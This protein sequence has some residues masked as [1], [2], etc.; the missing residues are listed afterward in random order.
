MNKTFTVLISFFGLISTALA[1]GTPR[2]APPVVYAAPVC[3]G[4]AQAGSGRCNAWVV[5]N[6]KGVPIATGLQAKSNKG[7]NHG[8]KGGGGGGGGGSS[9]PPPPPPGAYGPL[10]FQTAYGLIGASSGD[11]VAIVDAYNDPTAAQDLASYSS[12][13][14]LPSCTSMNGCFKVVNQTGGTS[15]PRNNSGWALE[16]SLDVQTVH[17]VCPSCSILL[18]EAQSSS[19]SNLLAAETYAEGHSDIVSNSWGGGEFSSETSY[20]KRLGKVPTTFSAGDS[21]YGVQWP[22]ASVNVTA[23]GGTTLLLNGDNTRYDET[24]WSGTGSGCSAYEPATGWQPVIGG[25]SKHRIVADVAADADPGTGAAVFDSYGYQGQAGW[26]TVGGTSLSSPIIASI[27]ALANNISG[28][29][30]LYQAY[31]NS[32]NELYDVYQGSNGNCASAL[33]N[34]QP[35]YDGPS[36]VGAPNGLAAFQ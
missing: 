14:S 29:D 31:N 23:V 24:V 2:A 17:A 33:C 10:Q 30:V 5:T 16:I 26:F 34:A 11:T 18:V 25:C 28:A 1:H 32:S 4:P 8:G 6:S 22:A 20:D 7:G 19:I 15:L 35:G 3:P 27:Y 13:F 21:G 36:G 9:S 12:V